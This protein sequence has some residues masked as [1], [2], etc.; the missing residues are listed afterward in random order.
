MI[1]FRRFAAVSELFIS[2][3]KSSSCS[4]VTTFAL[5]KRN[6][7]SD[8]ENMANKTLPKWRKPEGNSELRIY[9]SLTRE[10][11]S[12]SSR[13]RNFRIYNMEFCL[14]LISCRFR[15]LA[16]LVTAHQLIKQ[17]Y[18]ATDCFCCNCIWGYFDMLETERHN[19]NQTVRAKEFT[20]PLVKI[21]QLMN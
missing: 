17:G 2:S 5:S 3:V 10:K 18:A 16:D 21:Y 15:C 4:R 19:T 13:Y 14:F 8:P 20:Q 9:N 1:L 11:V 12:I 6:F 7:V